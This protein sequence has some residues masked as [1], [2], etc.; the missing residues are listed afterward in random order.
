M[1]PKLWVVLVAV[2]ILFPLDQATKLW[3]VQNVSPLAPLEVIEGFFRITHARN[4]GMALGLLQDVRI[5]VFILLS[6]AALAL[7]LSFFRRIPAGDLRSA[8][9]L[10][11]IL[12]GALGNL[13]DRMVRGEVIDFMQFNFGLFVFPDFNVADSAI[14][15]GVLLLLVDVVTAEAEPEAGGPEAGREP[16]S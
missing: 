14:V 10:G 13:V 9:A 1:T 3:V 2:A 11:L 7:V 5:E 8:T 4:P 15:I 12:S 6:L 16:S